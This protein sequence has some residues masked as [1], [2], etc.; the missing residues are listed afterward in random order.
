M[1]PSK[2]LSPELKRKIDAMSHLDMAR[3]WRF[4]PSGDDM[5]SGDAGKYFKS[6]FYDYFGG[7]TSAISKQ[8]GW[9]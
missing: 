4:S 8:V 1:D 7:W 9:G 5:L 3:K 2:N 6:R